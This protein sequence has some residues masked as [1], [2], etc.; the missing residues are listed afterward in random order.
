MRLIGPT[1]NMIGLP[2]KAYR[3]GL[4]YLQPDLLG[5]L[6]QPMYNVYLIQREETA[7]TVYIWVYIHN[8][9]YTKRLLQ[10][11][12]IYSLYQSLVRSIGLIKT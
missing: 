2:Y 11:I 5:A 12:G 6:G 8:T 3:V 10:S 4:S 1:V 9:R 7:Y